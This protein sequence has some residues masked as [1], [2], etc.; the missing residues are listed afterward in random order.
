VSSANIC[1]GSSA[2][3]HAKTTIGASCTNS[4]AD[5]AKVIT[6]RAS[7]GTWVDPHNRGKYQ[8][9]KS[10]EQG[11]VYTLTVHRT[12]PAGATGGQNTDH[13]VLQLLPSGSGCAVSTCSESQVTSVLDFGTNYCNAHDL[14]CSDAGCNAIGDAPVLSCTETS[15]HASSGQHTAAGCYKA[16][17]QVVELYR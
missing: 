9:V 2:F 1:P 8:L 14:F 5:V 4:C 17:A 13:V 12:T 15:V 16:S 3:I 10:D 7:S 11:G 6:G